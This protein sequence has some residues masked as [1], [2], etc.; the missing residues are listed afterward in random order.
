MRRIFATRY[1]LHDLL[2]GSGF[3]QLI[4]VTHSYITLSNILLK[5]VDMKMFSIFVTK[6]KNSGGS[7]H[8][9]K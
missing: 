6:I 9:W 3:Q 4:I 1:S 8:V 2:T 5:K 7:W